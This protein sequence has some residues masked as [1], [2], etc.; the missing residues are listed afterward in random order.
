[1]KNTRNKQKIFKTIRLVIVLVLVIL[2]FINGVKDFIQNDYSETTEPVDKPYAETLKSDDGKQTDSFT[3]ESSTEFW[4]IVNG[5][6]PYFSSEEIVSKSYESYSPLD[7]LERCGVAMACL[8]KDLMP[9][10]SRGDISSVHPTGW[11]SNSP[12]QYNR[13]HLIGYQL[14]GEN[15]NERNL[16]TGTRNFNVSGMLPFEN[17]VADYIK[18]TGNHVMYRVTPDFHGNNLVAGG[19]L[20]EGY[21]VEDD[22]EGVCFCVYV[23]NAQS[24][25][26]IDYETGEAWEIE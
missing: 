15:D 2:A 6:I 21:S 13:C 9:T 4:G 24:G 19:V 11:H 14:A 18:E 22:G 7:E 5:N 3:V 26:Q 20:M 25:T 23:Y 8:G 1:M 12:A 16:I 17:V 10:Q